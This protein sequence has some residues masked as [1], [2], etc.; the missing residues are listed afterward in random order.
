MI[1]DP[2]ERLARVALN[3][4][5]EPASPKVARLVGRLGVVELYERLL[6]DPSLEDLRSAS[7]ER[8]A[9]LDPA[10]LLG[11]AERVGIRFVAPGDEEWPEQLA[12]LET[13]EPLN[14]MA[15]P[16]LGLWVRGSGSL[17]A[18]CERA[19]A[20]VGSR[21]CTDYGKVV[22]G[23]VAAHLTRAGRT[24]VSGGAIG[25]DTAA[26]RAALGSHGPTVA[27]LAGG[28]DRPYPVGN[29]D[30]LRTI[31]QDGV[32]LSEA[33]PGW[34]SARHR[35]LARN[36]LIAALTRGTVVVEAAVRSGALN[37]AS[38][39]EL[40][41]RV[42]MGVPGPVFNAP[43]EGVHELIH[44]G[45]ASLVS[46]GEHVEDLVGAVGEAT[47][48]RPRAP[49]TLFDLLRPEDKRVLEAVPLGRAVPV[50]A[51]ARTAGVSAR[52]ARESLDRLLEEGWVTGGSGLWRQARRA[53]P[54]VGSPA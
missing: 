32:V 3:A 2:R 4:L 21:S 35:F 42:V 31:C 50:T 19:V 34:S 16:P 12:D 17:A 8:L 26:H 37:T 38:W 52:A 41:G 48:V 53:G 18:L 24:V 27:V 25:I 5:F 51:I 46:R 22:A 15:G 13:I 44:S 47:W 29:A 30:L 11:R 33:P 28:A 43:S 9:A 49:E 45:S 1:A 23:D 20:V 10:G 14:G 7:S 36:R 54:R 39:A 40:L 6:A